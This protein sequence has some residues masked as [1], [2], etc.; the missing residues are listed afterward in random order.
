[1]IVFIKDLMINLAM[2][3]SCIFLYTQFTNSLPI[4]RN[5]PFKT[6][7]LLGLLGGLLG[8][9]LMQYSIHIDETMVDLRHI[10][11]VLLA[12]YGGSLPALIAMILIMLG[13]LLFSINIAAVI[14]L[15]LCTLVSIWIANV[16]FS[17]RM[18]ILTTLT[19]ANTIL[20]V[21]F[22]FL[23]KDIRLLSHLLPSYWVISYLSGFFSF[24]MLEY[25]R[26]TQ[27]L[28]NQYKLES[29]TDGLT[30][31]NNVR[32][33]HE[34]LNFQW[35]NS[36][37]ESKKLCLLYI[38]IDFFKQ[39]NDTYGHKQGD[40]VLK[41]LGHILK[42]SIRSSD[43]VSRNGGEEFTVLLL[44]CP[45]N[46]AL[47]VSERIRASVENH[48][49]PL[50]CG[51]KVSITVSIGVACTGG[52]ADDS[53][54]LIEMADKALYQAKRTGRNKV[55]VAPQSKSDKEINRSV[56]SESTTC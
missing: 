14:Y 46:R 1:M 19:L 18:K 37:T 45:L 30:G 36:E 42:H 11:I 50:S 15:L 38:D 8:N 25:L 34:I 12:F 5:S 28:F 26:K 27:K 40:I 43:L 49:F 2:L 32:K 22:S 53:S 44:D 3:C 41:E 35:K 51:E 7:L 20:S 21:I 29:F 13:R 23:I 16:N 54:T 6:R 31:L 10:P 24:Y 9:I 17:K 56:D 55:C 48:V 4:H 47:E 33:F 52:T 39:V